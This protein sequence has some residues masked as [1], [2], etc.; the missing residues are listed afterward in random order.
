M[1]AYKFLADGAAGRFSGFTWPQPEGGKPGAWIV[2]DAVD[3]CRSGVHA[4]RTRDLLDWIDDELWEVELDGELEEQESMILAR[5]GRLLR[6]I[7][8]WDAAAAAAFADDCAWRAQAIAVRALRRDGATGEADRLEAVDDLLDVQ[9]LAALSSRRPE[10]AAAV[11]AGFAA[12]AVALARGQRPDTWDLG[13]ALADPA[14]VQT[15]AAIAANLGFVVAHVAGLEAVAATGDGTAYASGF[16][17]ERAAQL[18]WLEDR[19]PLR[20]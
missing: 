20:H 10:P 3:V 12:D 7:E 13:V 19:L 18:R 16:A 5:R 15:P 11:A 6:R 8:A 2:A 17:V 14:P 4:C 9:I 1:Q